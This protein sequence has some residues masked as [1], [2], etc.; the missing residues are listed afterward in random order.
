MKSVAVVATK[1]ITSLGNLDETW[2]RLMEGRSALACLKSGGFF[3]NLTDILLFMSKDENRKA[4]FENSLI[5][6]PPGLISNLP[7]KALM[8]PPEHRKKA[9]PVIR[10]LHAPF[11]S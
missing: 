1:A 8:I 3:G 5:E 10:R 9:E 4:F 7:V 2:S 6:N 11:K